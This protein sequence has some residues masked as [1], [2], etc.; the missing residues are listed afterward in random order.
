[1]TVTI[2]QYCTADDSVTR[3]T[4]VTNII[5]ALEEA[6]LNGDMEFI[7]Q[8][9]S[10]DDGQTKVSTNFRSI[11]EIANAHKYY[12]RIADILSRRCEGGRIYTAREMRLR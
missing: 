4:R 5:S 10:F 12:M 9:Y 7:R 1:M 8:G 2:E 6:M 11:N 3:L